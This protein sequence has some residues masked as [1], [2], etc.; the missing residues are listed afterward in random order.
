M[1]PGTPERR[2]NVCGKAGCRC[3][4]PEHPVKHGPYHRL[5][6]GQK[7]K[8]GTFPVRDGDAAAVGRMCAEFQQA[9][10]ILSG[11]ALATLELWR[12]GGVPKVEGAIRGLP[13]VGAAPRPSS[14]R[15]LKLAAS[16]DKWRA[17]A[18]GRRAELERVR[19]RM[20]DLGGSR[21]K[22]RAEAL[23]LRK[24]AARAE[25]RAAQLEEA[26][27]DAKKNAWP[28]T[29]GTPGKIRRRPRVQP[30]IPIRC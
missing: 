14:S 25:G 21:G 26:L 2:E 24:T 27:E 19:I 3:K 7:G 10:G 1:L 5:C 29:P 9:K 20:R 11:I 13:A 4:D 18:E 8:A 22:W 15:L 28:G 12:D 16:R 17:R 30:G 23:G 6:V